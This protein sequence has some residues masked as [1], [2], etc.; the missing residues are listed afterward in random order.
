MEAITVVP[1]SLKVLVLDLLLQM[2]WWLHK[3]SVYTCGTGIAN[4]EHMPII[5]M[6]ILLAGGDYID[7]LLTISTQLFW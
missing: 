1:R 4:V 2:F 7:H 5:N 6:F 3:F